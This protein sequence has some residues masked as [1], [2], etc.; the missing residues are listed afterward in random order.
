MSMKDWSTTAASNATIASNS[1][2]NWQEG[3]APST[4]ND[5]A[6]A[7]MADVRAWYEAAEWI[8]LGHAP[9]YASGT[10]FTV[11]GDK[12][13]I[14]TVGRRV[15]VYNGSSTFYATISAVSYST[16]TT[17][18]VVN[19][20]SALSGTLSTVAVGIINPSNSSEIRTHSGV[21]TFSSNPILSGGTANGIPYLDGSKNLVS[22]S[23]LSF[24]GSILGISGGKARIQATTGNAVLQVLN[25]SGGDGT[26]TATGTSNTL[27]WVF[28]TFHTGSALVISDDG[29]ITT[30]KSIS[31]GGATPAAGAGISF[32]ATQSASADANT[33][34]D[35]EEGAW[36]PVPSPNTGSFT[37]TS[38]AGNYVK[39]GRQVTVNGYISVSDRGTAT[40][41]TGFSGLPF[42]SNASSNAGAS[43]ACREQGNTGVVWTLSLSAN[44]SFVTMRDY[45]NSASISNGV[46][47][48]FT[49]VYEV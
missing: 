31:V 27:N 47:W 26:L 29:T 21:H 28:S 43:G 14:Y 1:G 23:A 12:T 2:I 18:T 42:T 13:A 17:V 34:D 3:Q 41:L 49:L 10:S 39:V 44:S 6:R 11:P 48:V 7:M 45:A 37:T 30:Q 24:D 40:G 8:D 46:A 16:N 15:K 33:L 35:Y 9:T 19:D 5:S 36:T 38:V 22:G 32:P 4:V 25:T 20:G